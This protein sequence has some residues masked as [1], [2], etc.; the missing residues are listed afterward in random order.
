MAL[1]ASI[2]G[3]LI[4]SLY[5]YPTIKT[6]VMERKEFL[7]LLGFGAISAA[8]PD[9]KLDRIFSPSI[10]GQIESLKKQLQDRLN[11]EISISWEYQ[12]PK[13]T[14][15][16]YEVTKERIF[17]FNYEECHS[18]VFHAE[19]FLS[20][21]YNQRWRKKPF[22]EH[23]FAE[24]AIEVFRR[25]IEL[26][27]HKNPGHIDAFTGYIGMAYLLLD[28]FDKAQEEF[29]K[30][31]CEKYF[32]PEYMHFT[33][34]ERKQQ[35]KEIYYDPRGYEF[36]KDFQFNFSNASLIKYKFKNIIHKPHELMSLN[37]TMN[38]G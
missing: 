3:A 7:K 33:P 23:Y 35:I 27:H 18:A 38:H 17:G 37:L 26:S 32:E 34:E 28:K 6:K 36:P 19:S 30:H 8:I 25:A 2:F 1:R 13:T 15:I 4:F 11:N 14:F 10:E 16:E 22:T 31:S 29:E 5:I 12:T 24:L 20:K 9:T 21:W